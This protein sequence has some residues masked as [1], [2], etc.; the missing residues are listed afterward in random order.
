[1]LQSGRQP[2]DRSEQMILNNFHA[3]QAVQHRWPETG[4]PL[5]PDDVL[6]LHS[7]VTRDTLDDERD[8]GRL[9]GPQD[10]RIVMGGRRNYLHRPPPAEE[11]PRRLELCASSPTG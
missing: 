10:E 8:A 11:L 9:Q 7:T 6:D 5:T 1:M 4:D 2:R 3:M